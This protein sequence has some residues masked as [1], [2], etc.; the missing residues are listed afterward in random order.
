MKK[1]IINLGTIL[2]KNQ[3]KEIHGN[4]PTLIKF[5]CLVNSGDRICCTPQHCGETGGIISNTYPGQYGT[6]N[7]CVC[8]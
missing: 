4:G 8:F 2:N 1:S 6:T 5:K 7:L 3:Q